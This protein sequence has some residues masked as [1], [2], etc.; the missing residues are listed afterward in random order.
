MSG[1][2][3]KTGLFELTATKAEYWSRRSWKLGGG[4]DWYADILRASGLR[5]VAVHGAFLEADA[6]ENEIFQSL[7]NWPSVH[8]NTQSASPVT[9]VPPQ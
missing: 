1:H 9:P 2:N 3:K 4:M 7:R 6:T 8:Q 5:V